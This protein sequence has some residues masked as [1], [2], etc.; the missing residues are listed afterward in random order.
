MIA[1]RWTAALAALAVSMACCG[2]STILDNG[3]G[4]TGGTGANPLVGSWNGYASFGSG[5]LSEQMTLRSDGTATAI[6]T[7]GGMAGGPC[8]GALDITDAWTS[9][10][11]TFSVSNGT[12]TGQVTCPID[13][14]IP[15]GTEETASQ[16]C[17]YT[18]SNGD[19][20]LVLDCPEGPSQITFTR[21]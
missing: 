17:T 10:P 18:L 15:C 13:G 14:T 11:T 12:C 21:Q 16:T 4:G 5:Y 19:D 20:M 2:G 8:T 1:S 9:T 6:D 3:T 7:F